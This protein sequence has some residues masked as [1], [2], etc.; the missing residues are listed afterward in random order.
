M[1]PASC[2]HCGASSV[3]RTRGLQGLGEIV[4]ALVLLC[5]GV[6]PGIVYYAWR[7]GIP[8]CTSCGRRVPRRGAARRGVSAAE[9]AV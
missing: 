7:E 2:P 4:S 5:C 8:Y 1:R 9:R 3:G 6:L